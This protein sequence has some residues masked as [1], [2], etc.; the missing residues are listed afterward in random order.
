[1]KQKLFITLGIFLLALLCFAGKAKAATVTPTKTTVYAMDGREAEAYKEKIKSIPANF[2]Q[3]YTIKVAGNKTTPIFEVEGE[4]GKEAINVDKNGKVTLKEHSVNYVGYGVYKEYEYGTFKIKIT[5]DGQTLYSTVTVES[6]PRYYAESIIDKYLKE[7][8]KPG[9]SGYEKIQKICEFVCSY[10]YSTKASGY[11]SMIL[12]GGGD[13]WAS[14]NTIVYMCKELGI[15]SYSRFAANDPGAGNGHR[16]AMAYVDG[17]YYE[18]EA[19]YNAKA[20]RPYNIKE[21]SG[22]TY[23]LKEDGTI[24]LTQYDGKET[25]IKV[26]EK[27]RYK[28]SHRNRRLCIL[29]CK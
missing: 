19:G 8:I 15:E 26:P 5:V 29:L 23:R 16:N 27:L 21:S 9:M 28:N 2:P 20:P 17:K 6:Y 7:N 14:T 24:I 1:M 22:W 13:C 18:I 3:S 10:D 4:D 25:N 12:T 11:T